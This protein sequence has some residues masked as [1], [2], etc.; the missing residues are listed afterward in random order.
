M[1]TLGNMFTSHLFNSFSWVLS[2][3]ILRHIRDKSVL[4]AWGGRY[5]EGEKPG[6]KP[7]ENTGTMHRVHVCIYCDSHVPLITYW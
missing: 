3:Q 6:E 1:Y 7:G 5:A 4:K 2:K